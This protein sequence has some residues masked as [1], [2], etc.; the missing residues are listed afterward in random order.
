M[1]CKYLRRWHQRHFCFELFEFYDMKQPDNISW[2]LFLPILKYIFTT[3]I[4]KDIIFLVKRG[5]IL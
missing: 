3:Y 1:S 5:I 2:L 4:L